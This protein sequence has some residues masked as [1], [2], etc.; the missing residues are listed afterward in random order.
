MIEIS[1]FTSLNLSHPF[2]SLEQVADLCVAV[3]QGGDVRGEPVLVLG[4]R[5]AASEAE[6]ADDLHVSVLG[7]EVER[8]LALGVG[9]VDGAAE[10]AEGLRD[11]EQALAG[12]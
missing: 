5:V 2:Q 4:R 1:A 10:G 7:G 11:H 9:E 6:A 8:V 3:G 12:G